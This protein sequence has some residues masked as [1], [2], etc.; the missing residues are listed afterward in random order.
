[1]LSSQGQSCCQPQSRI[2]R[3]FGAFLSP[4]ARL[5]PASTLQTGRMSLRLTLVALNLTTGGSGKRSPEAKSVM[6]IFSSTMLLMLAAVNARAQAPGQQRIPRADLVVV[7]ANV[8]TVDNARPRASAFA[9][10]DGRIIFVGS[11]SEART[12]AGAG[13]RM[14]DLHG[15]TVIPGMVDAHAHLSGLATALRNVKLAGSRTYDEVI[16]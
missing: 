7:N 5:G 14:L 9:V 16:R 3:K 15:S 6:K 10:G 11:D 4:T 13:T 1:M 8:Y 2:E 12:L